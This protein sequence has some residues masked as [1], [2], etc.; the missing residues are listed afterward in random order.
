MIFQT[1]TQGQALLNA[2][3]TSTPV[4]KVV[5]GSGVGYPLTGSPTGLVGSSVFTKDFSTPLLPFPST[6]SAVKYI[7][8]LGKDLG[9]FS[10]GEMALFSGATLL[11][12]GVENS[13]VLK[14]KDSPT[15]SGNDVRIE[16]YIDLGSSVR[17]TTGDSISNFSNDLLPR[18]PKV[19]YLPLIDATVKSLYSV[20]SDFSNNVPPSIAHS[21]GIG[22][23][24]LSDKPKTYQTGTV[25]LA[26]N[27]GISSTLV[28]TAY[29]G[30][31][32]STVIQFT[33]GKLRSLCRQLVS[34]LPTG[35]LSWNTPIPGLVF[36]SPGDKFV[37][38][39]PETTSATSPVAASNLVPIVILPLDNNILSADLAFK[40]LI[41]QGY[42]A[43]LDLGP[44][45]SSIAIGTWIQI[46]NDAVYNNLPIIS[47]SGVNT[48]IRVKSGRIANV[49]SLG[50]A[51]LI[52]TGVNSYHLFGDLDQ[53]F[54]EI[55]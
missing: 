22:R 26:G 51:T 45:N 5:L 54:T 25:T 24:S 38:L 16:A 9:A 32:S 30:N 46:Y 34:Y 50:N 19:D 11:A 43:Y 14:Q 1:T 36:P 37:I 8:D 27:S 3:P 40:Y 44:I 39:G 31:A 41:F 20:Y 18:I 21:D 15:T 42:E 4:T 7:I 2:S 35:E 52:K 17:L 29:S 49:S 53:G 48:S 23:W 13:L 28:G 10:F 47:S 55:Q 12:V 6:A 33:T